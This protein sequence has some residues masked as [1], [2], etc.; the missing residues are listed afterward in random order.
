[1]ARKK[2]PKIGR[3]PRHE[4][5]RLSKNRTF[6]IR[7]EL[8][9]RLQAAASKAGRSVSEEIEYRL[10]QSFQKE[11]I[12]KIIRAT[13]DTYRQPTLS[14]L[15]KRWEGG[16]SAGVPISEIGRGL[17]ELL[18]RWAKEIAPDAPDAPDVPPDK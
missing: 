16:Q 15:G 14:E 18:R 2:S 12:A 11:D 10:D 3:P 4:G 6:R 5:E 17:E 13:V 8:D 9:D 1:M 7:G